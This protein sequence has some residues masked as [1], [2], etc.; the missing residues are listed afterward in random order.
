MKIA[1][2]IAAL[3]MIFTSCS[4]VQKSAGESSGTR[5]DAAAPAGKVTGAEGQTLVETR[6]SVLFADGSL[7]EYT[8]SDYDPS[9]NL[10]KQSR[11]SASG[12]LLEQVE[13]AYREGTGRLSAKITRDGENQVKTR[14]EYEYDAQG[15]LT[16][17]TLFNKSGQAISSYKYGYDGK[18]NRTSRAVSNGAGVKLAETVF[19]FNNA[20]LA[21]GSETRD[22]AGKK[23]NS[24]EN[25]YDP[26]G[27]LILQK[28]YNANGEIA[29]EAGSVWKDG[30]EVVNEQRGPDGSVQVR[31]TS[32]YGPGNE[33]I[34]KTVENIQGKSIQITQYEYRPGPERRGN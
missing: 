19:T 23:I 4:T 21:A 18:G 33:L 11:Y 26:G 27:N 25:Q 15:R 2:I 8:A 3:T 5:S 34:R 1:L 22:G 32:E 28:V 24:V 7:D 13:Y 30:L 14:V 31:V 29:S 9:F 10:V 6:A 12:T 16:V 20:G 17:E